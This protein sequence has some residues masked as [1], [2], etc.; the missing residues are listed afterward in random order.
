MNYDNAVCLIDVLAMVPP[1]LWLLSAHRCKSRSRLAVIEDNFDKVRLIVVGS[2]INKGVKEITCHF[3]S[4][5]VTV[6]GKCGTIVLFKLHNSR[7][8]I[9][10]SQ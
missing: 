2:F 4:L 3:D 7:H 1:L 10:E 8:S 9:P 6:F 5:V